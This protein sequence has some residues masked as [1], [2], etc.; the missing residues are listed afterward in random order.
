M[1]RPLHLTIISY[2]SRLDATLEAI[3]QTLSRGATDDRVVERAQVPSDLRFLLRQWHLR[4]RE[5]R[6]VD[7]IGHGD[8][9]RFKLGD[10]LLFASDGTGLAQID[11]LLPFLS[12][13]ATL[14]LLGC[15][16]SEPPLVSGDLF[17]GRLLLRVLQDRL[18]ANRRVLAP[19]RTLFTIDYGEQGLSS[20][21]LRSLTG[22]PT[23]RRNH[24][25]T[26][27]GDG[28][29]KPRQAQSHH[30]ASR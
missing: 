30:A 10:E 17:D 18:G 13:R 26:K 14:R 11:E 2:P 20:R 23:P 9:G 27:E 4:D 12:P 28:K 16:V 21:A 24:G 5:L 6:T 15:A 29:R 25:R 1:R 8:G 3:A 7:L 22:S 19:S